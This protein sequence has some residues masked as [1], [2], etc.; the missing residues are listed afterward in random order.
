MLTNIYDCLVCCWLG[1]SDCLICWFTR[2][3]TMSFC[4]VEAWNWFEAWCW[5]PCSVVTKTLTAWAWSLVSGWAPWGT[6]WKWWATTLVCCSVGV[7]NEGS[8][9]PADLGL[10]HRGAFDLEI[11]LVTV[12]HIFT[13]KN[14]FQKNTRKKNT[15]FGKQW[16]NKYLHKLKQWVCNTP[17]L[18]V[19][20]HSVSNTKNT[21]WTLPKKTCHENSPSY[22]ARL[23][24][25]C[26]LDLGNIVLTHS[27]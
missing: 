17:A 15:C 27:S 21:T 14:T 19:T 1:I 24:E 25:K 4:F 2:R 11:T 12:E 9:W 20:Q 26:R 22:A 10:D 23:K 6:P 8:G 7:G 16:Q 3:I 13:L 5:R 18:F